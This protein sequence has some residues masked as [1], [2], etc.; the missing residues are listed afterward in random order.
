VHKQSVEI[1]CFFGKH[2]RR[3]TVNDHRYLWLGFR[4]IYRGIRGGIQ[5]HRWMIS[6][7][8][9]AQ[10]FRPGKIRDLAI[11]HH[12]LTS[13]GKATLQLCANLPVRA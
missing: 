9:P 3:I 5:N 8:E 1:G 13:I 12:N 7:K 4:A 10:L 11:A 2:T 6:A